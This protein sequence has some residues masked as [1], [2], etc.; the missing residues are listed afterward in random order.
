MASFDGPVVHR[1]SYA[2]AQL[3][4]TAAQVP[5]EPRGTGIPERA[6]GGGLVSTVALGT[7]GF[8]GGEASSSEPG[9]G[10]ATSLP[11]ST[12]PG[13]V[14][15]VTVTG[16]TADPHAT[17]AIRPHPSRAVF[18]GRVRLGFIVVEC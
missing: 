18:R 4:H 6:D 15:G 12:A 11:A 17:P 1:H 16:P 14:D 7:C 13:V 3:N 10:V 8:A 2:Q 5:R 9:S